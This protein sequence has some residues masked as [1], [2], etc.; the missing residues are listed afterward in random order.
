MTIESLAAGVSARRTM[1]LYPE[2]ASFRVDHDSGA[3][4]RGSE[5]IFR[6]HYQFCQL[7]NP[8][9]RVMVKM[10]EHRFSLF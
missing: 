6:A 8:A 5:T 4:P 2:A 7:Q 3:V 1:H 10:S 9:N